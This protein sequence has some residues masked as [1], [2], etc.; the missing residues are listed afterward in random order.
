ML[1]NYLIVYKE[2]TT[3][4][5]VFE[6]QNKRSLFYHLWLL[7]V[8]LQNNALSWKPNSKRQSEYAFYLKY[9]Y[10]SDRCTFVHTALYT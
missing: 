7:I 2:Y 10:M 9:K 1:I 3:F 6:H 8:Y 4:K 5:K